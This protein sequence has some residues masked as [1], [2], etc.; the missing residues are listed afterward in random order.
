MWPR[1]QGPGYYD[2]IINQIWPDNPPRIVRQEPEAEQILA[3]VASGTAIAVLDRHRAAKLCPS[4]VLIRR[5]AAPRPHTELTLIWR[6]TCQSAVLTSFI[7]TV[8]TRST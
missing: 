3:A 6:S 2:R 8:R 1:V 4:N 7:R 5:F